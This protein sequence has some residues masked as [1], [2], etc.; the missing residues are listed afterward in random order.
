MSEE[1][2]SKG[3]PTF[4]TYISG[5]VFSYMLITALSL[6]MQSVSEGTVLANQMVLNA[7]VLS[8]SALVS[9]A[10]IYFM[11]KGIGIKGFAFPLIAELVK[12]GAITFL[13]KGMDLF[14]LQLMLGSLIGSIL[15][16]KIFRDKIESF[17]QTG[18]SRN[19][20]NILP[21]LFM[22]ILFTGGSLF[23]SLGFGAVSQ[24]QN[25][26]NFDTS[27]VDFSIFDIPAWNAAYYL[28]NLMDQMTSGLSDP[29]AVLFNVTI[30]DRD[31]YEDD[32][33][34]NPM[35]YYRTGTSD[36]YKWTEDEAERGDWEISDTKTG[37][38]GFHSIYS[39]PLPS[40]LIN[41]KEKATALR[42]DTVVTLKIEQ[43]VKYDANTYRES[44]PAVWNGKYGSYIDPF[45]S[46][47][48]TDYFLEVDGRNC[49]D[50]TCTMY[51]NSLD[52]S[53][54][55]QD[56]QSVEA[57]IGNLPNMETSSTADLTYYQ[58]YKTPNFFSLAMYAQPRSAYANIVDFDETTRGLIFDKYTHLPGAGE[59]PNSETDYN[60]WV[61]PNPA[62][63]Y[64]SQ[65]LNSA[66]GHILKQWSRDLNDT[67]DLDGSSVFNIAL[68]VTQ[69]LSA[70]GVTA[71]ENADGS[72]LI[73]ATGEEGDLIFDYGG[74]VNPLQRGDDPDDG[75]IPKEDQ[76]YAEWFLLRKKGYA[77]HFATTLALILRDYG[78]PTRLVNGYAG[79]DTTT[80]SQKILMRG[81]Y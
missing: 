55:F 46:Y 39:Q 52:I 81:M 8:A 75:D 20:L 63:S 30:V 28:Q 67:I 13:V 54:S 50:L 74:W 76:D 25:P 34:H 22:L 1:L 18:V 33:Y 62:V 73:P 59:L 47:G 44:L 29:T 40:N 26:E 19:V 72:V 32:P 14:L 31:N 10:E 78:I 80:D 77:I 51:E 38:V 56:A 7:M 58:Q 45:L 3:M 41:E 17:S 64:A 53:T 12:F 16:S 36:L 48:G 42:S 4:V 37:R 71:L 65:G 15:I 35:A 24:I 79:G 9:L 69:N 49:L 2:K 21:S 70:R 5:I 60:N 6:M 43:D 66:D 27:D 11:R 23:S 57:E 68:A 61:H